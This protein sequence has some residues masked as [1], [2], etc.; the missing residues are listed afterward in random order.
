MLNPVKSVLN[1]AAISNNLEQGPDGIWVSRHR[2]E[3]SYPEEGNENCLALEAESY[4]FRHR[5]QCIQAV[6]KA[7]PPP[8]PVFDVGGGNGYVAL[9]IQQ[10]GFETVLVEPGWQGVQNAQKRGVQHLICSTLEDAQFQLG[11][12]PAVGMFDVLEHIADDRQF[13]MDLNQLLLPGGHVYLTVPAYQSLWSIGDD[14]SGHYRRYTTGLLSKVLK[15][16]GFKILFSTYIFFML[17][18]P[19]LL[20]RAIPSRLGMLRADD[21]DRYNNEHRDREDVVGK[22]LHGLLDQELGQIRKGRALPIGGSCLVAAQ[23]QSAGI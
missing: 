23:K 14:Y 13:L 16:A 20:M 12:L 11:S 7:F 3:I 15:Q 18:L 22:V 5:N 19:I 4:W 10:A 9:G 6:L 1:F 8:G 2:S 21:W 17:P